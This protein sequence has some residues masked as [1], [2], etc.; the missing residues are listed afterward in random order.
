[1]AFPRRSF[2]RNF[3]LATV[4]LV[5]I[6]IAK[7]FKWKASPVATTV[8]KTQPIFSPAK[9]SMI[10][11]SSIRNRLRTVVINKDYDA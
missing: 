6:P 1:M 7:V 8:V 2:L 5:A 3:V 11:G 10:M 4:G 9:R